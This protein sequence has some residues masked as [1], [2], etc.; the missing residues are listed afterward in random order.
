MPT[1]DGLDLDINMADG[2]YPIIL[3]GSGG[4]A[5]S[6]G[7]IV[8]NRTVWPAAGTGQLTVQI[9]WTEVDSF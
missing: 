3:G 4:G 6:H 8:R 2:D 7:L 1:T 5:N 9:A